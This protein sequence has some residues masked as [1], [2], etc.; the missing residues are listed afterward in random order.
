MLDES[1]VLSAAGSSTQRIARSIGSRTDLCD[2]I[3][4]RIASMGGAQERFVVSVAGPISHDNRVIRK[5]TNVLKNDSDIPI[6]EM[7]ETETR[8][9]LGRDIRLYVIKDAVAS[10]LAEMGPRGAAADRDEVLA[11][12][13]GTGT[14]GAPCRRLRSGEVVFPDSLADLGH[15]QVDGQYTE[16]CNCGARGCVERQTSG[17]AIVRHFRLRATDP[18]YAGRYA[19]SILHA[20]PGTRPGTISAQDIARA[21]RAGDGFTIE[22]LRES[23]KPLSILLRNIFTS[24]PGMTVALVGG[25][26]LGMGEVF[27]ALVREALIDGG[28]PFV[29]KEEVEEFVRSRLLLGAISPDQTNLVGA[30]LFLLQEE[31]RLFA[32]ES[33][34]VPCAGAVGSREIETRIT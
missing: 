30:R 33:H 15:H 27:L 22:V 34:R 5:Y 12:I 4:D 24:H 20:E 7:V 29:R 18:L 1:G 10:S 11:L 19:A 8:A 9:R 21:A 16:P 3:V 14:G 25:F 32:S 2:L 23:A 13:L 28:V 6:A 17:P 26:A 31:K